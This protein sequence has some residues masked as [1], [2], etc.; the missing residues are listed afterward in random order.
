MPMYF[1]TMKR[2]GYALFSTTPTERVAVGLTEDQ[3]RLHLLLRAEDGWSVVREW[4]VEEY[5]H[6]DLMLALGK[7]EEPADPRAVL[8][9]VPPPQALH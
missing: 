9:L 5:S 1:V 8:G 7:V 4:P 2:I 6:T 3:K